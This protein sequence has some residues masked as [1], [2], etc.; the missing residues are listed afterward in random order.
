MVGYQQV[1]RR[2]FALF[3]AEEIHMLKSFKLTGVVLLLA[4]LLVLLAHIYIAK[5][6]LSENSTRCTQVIFNIKNG[7][8]GYTAAEGKNT[9]CRMN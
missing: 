2:F 8:F 7:E 9:S 3:M 5:I 6:P 4:L 1:G